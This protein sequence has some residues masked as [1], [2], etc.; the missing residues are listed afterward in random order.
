M[1]DRIH[2]GATPLHLASMA[3]HVRVVE[4]LLDHGADV[5]ASGKKGFT[6]L[7]GAVADLRRDVAKL[8]ISRG[9]NV[10]A[11]DERGWP[12]LHAVFLT[13]FGHNARGNF[14]DR[15]ELLAL[16]IDNGA[17]VNTRGVSGRTV[18]HS[19]AQFGLVSLAEFLIS[20]GADVNAKDDDGNTPLRTSS[21]WSGLLS[22]EGQRKS[23]RDLAALLRRHGGVE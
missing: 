15:W 12:L 1:D 10:N 3:G 18:L 21:S 20:K 22:D 2:I 11:K 17:D 13:F 6:P 5:N 7:C 19:A 23:Y 8:L 4:F 14:E 16:L 9:A